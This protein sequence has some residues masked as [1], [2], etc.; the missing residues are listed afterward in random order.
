[1]AATAK[2]AAMRAVVMSVGTASAREEAE[3]ARARHN[4]DQGNETIKTRG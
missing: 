4:D 3:A 1:M 2:G